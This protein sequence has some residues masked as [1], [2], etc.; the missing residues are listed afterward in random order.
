MEGSTFA[1]PPHRFEAGTCRSRRPSGWARPCD[2]LTAV[3]MDAIAGARA[4]THRYALQRLAEVAGVRIIGPDT[5]STAAERSRSRSTACTRTT[6]AR[7]STTAGSRFARA[8][9]APGRC[10]GRLASRRRPGRLYLYNTRD[11]IDALIDGVRH[12]QEFFGV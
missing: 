12:A 4:G 2:Y 6:S 3:G 5:Q 1:A 7:C 10:T 8:I 11:E 9:T